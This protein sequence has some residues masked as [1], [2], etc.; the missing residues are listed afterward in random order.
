MVAIGNLYFMNSLIREYYYNE[1]NQRNLNF[2]HY[3]VISF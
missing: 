3:L 1:S 2:D